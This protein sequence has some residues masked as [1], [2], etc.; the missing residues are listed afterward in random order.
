MSP[1]DLNLGITPIDGDEDSDP[2]LAIDDP[3]GVSPVPLTSTTLTVVEGPIGDI[4]APRTGIG[5]T[6]E[7]I[8]SKWSVL[9]VL[10][11][12]SVSFCLWWTLKIHPND[13]FDDDMWD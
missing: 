4:L 13:D 11:V 10:A 2:N 5:R 12:F 6:S 1:I 3:E 8:L 7:I 9:V